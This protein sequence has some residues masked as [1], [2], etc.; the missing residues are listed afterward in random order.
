MVDR[1]I[2]KDTNVF[3]CFFNVLECIHAVFSMCRNV[4]EYIY[5]YFNVFTNIVIDILPSHSHYK[6]FCH[7]H[8]PTYIFIFYYSQWPFFQCALPLPSFL[9]FLL[10]HSNFHTIY[11]NITYQFLL[12]MSIHYPT[13]HIPQH[14][15]LCGA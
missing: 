13:L 2:I 5:V 9:P 1:C 8:L 11:K 7:M 3:E 12:F 10:I 6:C 4:F 15:W 14:H